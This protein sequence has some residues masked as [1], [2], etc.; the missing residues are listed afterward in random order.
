MPPVLHR[1]LDCLDTRSVASIIER[2]TVLQRIQNREVILRWLML[3]DSG[4]RCQS[5]HFE[6]GPALKGLGS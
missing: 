1:Y 2:Q 3:D 5:V 4:C 6:T